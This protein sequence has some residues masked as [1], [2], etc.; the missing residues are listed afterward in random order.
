M[1][2]GSVKWYDPKTDQGVVE[3][4]GREYAVEGGD[5]GNDAKWAG[6][7][8]HFDIDRADAGDIA[9]AVELRAGSR[10]SHKSSRTGDLTGAHDPA[11]KG[12]DEEVNLNDLS[13]RR[14]AYGDRPQLLVEDWVRFLGAGAVDRAAEL[15][16]PD[17][18]IEEGDRRYAGADDRARWL[19][20]SVLHGAD[21][22]R[23]DITGD[24][25]DGFVVRWRTVPGE[26]AAV[27]TRVTVSHGR[28]T[29]QHTSE[30]R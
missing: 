14:R 7:P 27:E 9:T 4:N 19:Q 12:Q 26:Q 24:G 18:T 22:G 16:A 29:E 30:Q 5:I 8:V 10:T 6:A 2:D 15:Y 25:A 28:I 21:A 11:D 17:A 23:A 20:D 1:P 3:H 13:V